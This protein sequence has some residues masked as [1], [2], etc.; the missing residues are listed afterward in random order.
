MTEELKKAHALL[1]DRSSKILGGHV[2]ERMLLDT[3]MSP[4]MVYTKS[5]WYSS[6]NRQCFWF[7]EK[8]ELSGLDFKIS[9][10]LR[11]KEHRCF[12]LYLVGDSWKIHEIKTDRIWN[13]HDFVRDFALKKIEKSSVRS[14]PSD[15][16]S[17]I[18]EK[19]ISFYQ[20]NGMLEDIQRSIQIEDLFLNQ[21]F[22]T[23]NIDLFF[24][25][26][27]GGELEPLCLEIKFKDAFP[28]KEKGKDV[29][30]IECF[31]MDSIFPEIE[32][33]GIKVYVAI[34]YDSCRDRDH[35][36]STNIFRYL[37][38]DVG[39]EWL[40]SRVSH[41][42]TY[43]KYTMRSKKTGFT[44]TAQR[45]RPVYCIPKENFD[46]LTS[47]QALIDSDK[48]INADGTRV[49]LCPQCRVPLVLRN[50]SYGRFWGCLNYPD[51]KYTCNN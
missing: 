50:G 37:D 32:K 35:V 21:Y 12:Q 4:D 44:G 10:L 41:K 49:R 20:Q 51:C 26:D 24:A 18:L 34:L 38:A 8:A 19:C 47:L 14:E 22:Y 7:V 42:A 27:V 5:W 29:M 6:A 30:G 1:G 17:K 13:I 39:N 48:L 31:Q 15:H 3:F 23:S 46:A 28:L 43:W 25:K 40:F 9:D 11:A 33:C 36:E 45:S 16:E 2:T